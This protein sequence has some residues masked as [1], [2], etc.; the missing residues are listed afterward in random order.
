MVMAAHNVDIDTQSWLGNDFH[1]QAQIELTRLEASLRE[2]G[3]QLAKLQQEYDDIAEAVT[4]LR[5]LL[6]VGE[7]EGRLGTP[8]HPTKPTSSKQ[9]TADADLVVGYLRESGAPVHYRKIYADVANL[10]V[11]AGG[12]DPANTLLARYYNDPRL[13]RVGRGTYV[14]KN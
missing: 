14:A 12:Q 2:R 9:R 3:G 6:Q 7:E 11:S 1:S 8:A 4:H 13:K 10:G 5:G